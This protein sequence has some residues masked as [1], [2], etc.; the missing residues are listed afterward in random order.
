[1]GHLFRG[2]APGAITPFEHGLSLNPYDPQNFVWYNLRALAY[3]FADRPEIGL[4]A[5][6][7]GRRIRPAWRPV[8]ETLACCYSALGRAQDAVPCIVQMRQLAPAES[9]LKPLKLRNPHWE[10]RLAKLLGQVAA[11]AK[12]VLVDKNEAADRGGEAGS[13]PL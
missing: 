1:M 10:D 2:N 11:A 5:A 7:K 13:R 4:V 9:G 12:P 8:H 6:T 3:L